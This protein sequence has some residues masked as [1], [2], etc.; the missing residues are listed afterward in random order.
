LSRPERAG[1]VEAGVMRRGLASLLDYLEL[2]AE[3]PSYAYLNRI[4]RQACARL[5]YDGISRLVLYP[6]GETPTI[7]ELVGNL[8]KG[9][10]GPCTTTN[11]YLGALLRMLG[12]PA[13]LVGVQPNHVAVLTAAPDLG[14]ELV[15]VDCGAK[16]PFF[17]A[18]R[19]ET[20]PDNVSRFGGE[21][22]RIRAHEAWP[23][24]YRHVKLLRGV[25]TK[26]RWTFDAD[27]RG[28]TEAEVDDLSRRN[29]TRPEFTTG[30]SFQWWDLERGRNLR[31]NGP[32]FTTAW[33]DGRVEARTLRA[34][35]EVEHIVAREFGR[36]ALPVRQAIE[37]LSRRGIDVF[38]TPSGAGHARVG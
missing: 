7:E 36:P 28:L 27:A 21:E 14:S 15:Y 19:F 23:R 8:R 30:L 22:V 1:G 10:G 20:N 4:A 12:F 2:A 16:A 5:P 33:R 18:V 38:S 3:P 13:R 24:W 6:H 34:V 29:M 9:F 11:R 31:L 32:R 35:D 25:V 17:E 37:V 26:S